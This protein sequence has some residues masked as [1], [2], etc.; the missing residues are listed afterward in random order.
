MRNSIEPNVQSQQ[1]EVSSC[2]SESGFEEDDEGLSTQQVRSQKT[3]E[4]IQ[5]GKRALTREDSS[6]QVQ[7]NDDREALVPKSMPLINKE[8]SL[9]PDM[10]F[11]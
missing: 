2:A 5:K 1:L 11:G 3:L 9:K 6:T 8:F 7:T 10:M 4:T